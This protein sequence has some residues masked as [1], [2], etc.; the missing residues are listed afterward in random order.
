MTT[1]SAWPCDASTCG[2]DPGLRRRPDRAVALLLGRC[3]GCLRARLCNAHPHASDAPRA[4][5][6]TATDQLWPRLCNAHLHAS[7]A[8]R[9]LRLR[10]PP[11]TRGRGFAMH[12]STRPAHTALS[13]FDGHQPPADEALQCAP[14]RVRCAFD[15]RR[16]R[17][18][19]GGRV[20]RGGARAVRDSHGDAPRHRHIAPQP[21][22]H[23]LLCPGR[24]RTTSA[25]STVVR[26]PGA[27]AA[28]ATT[29]MPRVRSHGT[30]LPGPTSHWLLRSGLVRTTRATST[31]FRTWVRRTDRPARGRTRRGAHCKARGGPTR[32]A[33]APD[34]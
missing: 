26:C 6:S 9:A 17:A 8:Y 3:A 11:A 1:F 12:T 31:V 21:P 14:P 15:A 10:R 18:G 4:A 7:G 24:V 30:S 2:L 5:R 22:S 33:R 27:R 16:R 13:A 32:P 19:R 28:G 25:T 34:A 29:S 20:G 23:W